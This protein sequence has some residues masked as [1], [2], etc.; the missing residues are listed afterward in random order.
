MKYL[1]QF[2]IIL[3]FSLL[4]EVLSRVIP[5]SIP[6]SVYGIL[7]LFLALCIGL[8][9]VEQVKQTAN[10]LTDLLPLLFVPSVAGLLENWPLIR[11]AIVPALLL[12]IVSTVLTFGICGRVTQKILEREEKKNG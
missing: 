12:V 1:N 2:C 7:L 4:G 10:F 6:G 11:N 9:K 8:V 3:C 5:V